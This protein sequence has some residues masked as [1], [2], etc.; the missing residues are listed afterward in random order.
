M[1]QATGGTSAGTFAT[2]SGARLNLSGMAMPTGTTFE[3]SGP[4]YLDGSI[5]GLVT[6]TTCLLEA[7]TLSGAFTVTGTLTWTGGRWR[8]R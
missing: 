2:P 8:G 1:L 6:G 3:G 4:V 7:G 5:T